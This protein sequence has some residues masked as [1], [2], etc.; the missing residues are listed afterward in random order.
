MAGSSNNSISPLA[1]SIIIVI[2]I[3]LV[4]AGGLWFM[5]KPKADPIAEAIHK[6]RGSAAPSAAPQGPLG[7][8][9]PRAG[10][11]DYAPAGPMPTPPSGR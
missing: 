7:G 8:Q 1:A 10:A 2:V 4:V 3:V 5:N 6:E 11:T 9:A